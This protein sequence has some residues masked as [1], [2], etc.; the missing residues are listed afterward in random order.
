MLNNCVLTGRM[1]RDPELRY[2]A[3]QTPVAAFTIAC[4]RDAKNGDE[5][6]TD[7]IDMV[8]WR[9]TG[10]FI[11]KYFKKGSL[12]TCLGRL[13]I[14]EWKDKDGNNRRSAEVVVSQ[15]YFGESTKPKDDVEFTPTD[16]EMPF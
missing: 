5:R 6:V 11:S 10:E 2:T 12:I 4:E 16:E 7:F 3:N 13:Q 8:A 14:R 1:V 15:A 9:Q